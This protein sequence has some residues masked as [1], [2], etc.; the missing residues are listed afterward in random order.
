VI[1]LAS[2]LLALFVLPHPWGVVAVAGAAT[3]EIAETA[4]FLWWSQRRRASVGVESL[5]GARGVA[6]SDLWPEGQVK[7]RGEI[8]KARCRAGAQRGARI[9]VR[10]VD[11]LVLEVDPL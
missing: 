2:I 4:L 5:E 1:L 7:V 6:V 10:R 9:V 3:I 11:G 8:W